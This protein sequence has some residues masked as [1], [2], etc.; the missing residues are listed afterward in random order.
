[1]QQSPVKDKSKSLEI[2]QIAKNIYENHRDL[3]MN[4]WNVA[5][6]INC[7]LPTLPDD[8]EIEIIEKIKNNYS[9][10]MDNVFLEFTAEYRYNMQNI[11]TQLIQ[12]E[13]SDGFCHL[14]NQV[15]YKEILRVRGLENMLKDQG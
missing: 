2:R 15:A 5:E 1:M 8:E 14:Y 10:D 13:P 6:G 7:K 4:L 11:M 3:Q 12:C 9:N